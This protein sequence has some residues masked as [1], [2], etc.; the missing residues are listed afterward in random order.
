MV[1]SAGDPLELLEL[2]RS[3]GRDVELRNGRILVRPPWPLVRIVS[4]AT[5]QLVAAVLAGGRTGHV[6]ARCDTCGEGTMRRP[7][8]TAPKRC[9]ITPACPGSHRAEG[10]KPKGPKHPATFS[11]EIIPVLAAQLPPDAYPL[12][13]DPFAGT[14]RI[15]ELP[16]FTVGVEISHEYPEH[17]RH[18][19][20][21]I[22]D[23]LALPFRAES[24]DAIA[25]SP[26]YG[27]RLTDQN[28]AMDGSV[29]HSYTHDLGRKLHPNNSGGM[30]W[31]P[32]Y[33]TFRAR[34]WAS[35][36]RVL[37]PGGRFVLNISD[38]IRNRQRQRVTDWHV[39]TLTKLGMREIDRIDI[40]T[41]RLRYGDKRRGARRARARHRLR[42]VDVLCVRIEARQGRRVHQTPA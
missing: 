37:R 33:R 34:A 6:W 10:A 3:E 18:P 28:N 27:N 9:V 25:T 19:N 14:G 13:L 35:V 7:K 2:L 30:H 26:T 42:A 40:P 31:G 15:H 23:A 1:M 38:H 5:C 11:D 24:F 17:Y 8:G 12:V 39:E 36:V 29:R 20:N 16:N 22:G 21:I 4:A 32:E 41:R